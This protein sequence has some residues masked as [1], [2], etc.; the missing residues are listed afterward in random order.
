ML[1]PTPGIAARVV[2]LVA[3]TAAIA[4]LGAGALHAQSTSSTLAGVGMLRL[5]DSAAI[6]SV[7]YRN[8]RYVI[9]SPYNIQY[10]AR[11]KAGS[12]DTRILAY[13]SA[14]DLSASCADRVDI[15]ATGVSL[16]Q[17]KAHDAASPS[18]RWIATDASGAPM[19]NANYPDDTLANVGS[20]SY[21]TQW[22]QNVAQFLRKNHFSGVFIDNVLGDVSG[23][24]DGRFPAKYRSDKAW[25]DAMA[26]FIAQISRILHAQGFYVAANAYKQFPQTASWWQRIGPSTDALMSE[27]WQQDPNTRVLQTADGAATNHWNDGERLMEIAQESGSSFLG[28]QVGAASDERLMRYGRASFL[29]AWNGKDG[30]YIFNPTD[31]A[32]PWSAAW[33]IDVGDPIEARHK[34]GVG[35]QRAYS[36]GMVLLNPSASRSQIFNL[37][38]PY[39]LSTGDVV[40]SV[41]LAPT[42]AQI[43]RR[44]GDSVSA[45]ASPAKAHAPLAA[46]AKN[47][48]KGL[49]WDGRH[50]ADRASF[51]IWLKRHHLG[52]H[53]WARRYPAAARA[54]GA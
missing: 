30:A 16:A 43:L 33:T 18:D 34:V 26:G 1:R 50:F 15:C 8:S 32:D 24:T 49:N 23:W 19:V 21:R 52:W 29:L 54:L 46:S 38:G 53:A 41:T 5:G 17:A 27:Y 51:A 25:E 40:S 47:A 4:L 10:A 22:A 28:L 35:W 2:A 20:P 3:L 44:V 9:L 48:G 7:H 42:S 39:R 11:I 14:M 36:E 31:S 37:G 6:G 13:K 45:K 12:P